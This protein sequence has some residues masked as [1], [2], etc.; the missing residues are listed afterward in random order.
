MK[1]K[2]LVDEAVTTK[3]DTKP[4]ATKDKRSKCGQCEKKIAF[5]VNLKQTLINSN[6]T[7]INIFKQIEMP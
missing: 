4:N 7:I 5:T 2:I 6:Q 3:N 1:L